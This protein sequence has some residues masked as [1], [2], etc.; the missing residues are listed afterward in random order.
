MHFYSIEKRF[1]T[2]FGLLTLASLENKPN[3]FFVLLLLHDSRPAFLQHR[4]TLPIFCRQRGGLERHSSGPTRARLGRDAIGRRR[5]A[6]DATGP[7]TK[8]ERSLSDASGFSFS[9]GR[10]RGRDQTGNTSKSFSFI[11]FDN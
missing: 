5:D 2:I 10:D 8:V 4:K 6:A 3:C 11:N 7:Q 9:S 1:E